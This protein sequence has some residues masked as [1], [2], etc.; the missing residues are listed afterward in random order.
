MSSG[1][2]ILLL[3]YLSFSFLE[4]F[5]SDKKE[6][7][8]KYLFTFQLLTINK[9][10]HAFP[11]IICYI[12]MIK[13]KHCDVDAYHGLTIEDFNSAEVHTA[14]LCLKCIKIEALKAIGDFPTIKSLKIEPLL[15]TLTAS[16]PNDMLTLVFIS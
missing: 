2:F 14:D 16:I 5:F 8:S 1:F 6:N 12:L 10:I 3:F 11:G 13:Y 15:S 9:Y 4:V 7:I